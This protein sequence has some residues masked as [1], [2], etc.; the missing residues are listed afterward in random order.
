MGVA[1]IRAFR[2]LNN[3]VSLTVTTDGIYPLPLVPLGTKAYRIVNSAGTAI[4]FEFGEAAGMTPATTTTSV[5]MLG[6]T[7]E[8]FTA[9][10]GKTHISLVGVA[11]PVYITPGEGI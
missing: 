7:V 8:V 4:F 6:N 5:A 3:N 11:G 2:P 1:Q 9:Q 10:V